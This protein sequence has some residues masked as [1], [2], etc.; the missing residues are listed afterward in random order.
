MPFNITFRKMKG[1]EFETAYSCTATGQA[2]IIAYGR[3][4]LPDSKEE[5]HFTLRLITKNTSKQQ[6]ENY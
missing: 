1:R 4:F 3:D 2:T 5:K 6:L